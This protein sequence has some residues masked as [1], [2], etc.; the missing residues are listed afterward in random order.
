MQVE[1][2]EQA[3]EL[4]EKANASLQ[5]ELLTAADARKVLGL[6]GRGEK[7]CGFGVTSVAH[8]VDDASEI[9]RTTGT[10]MGKAKAVAETG[11]VMAHSAELTSALQ[12]GVISLDQA[13]VIAAAEASAP[14]SAAELVEVART[15]S[16]A[17]LKERARKAKL[18][19]EQHLGLA[20]RQ[21][22]ARFA[23]SHTD[24]LG[25]VH[26]HLAW[27]PHVGSPIVGRAEAEAARLARAA[28]AAGTTEPFERHLADA[29]ASMMSGGGKGRA[30]RPELV[31]LVSHEV[32]TR[33]WKDVRDGEIC[34]VPG[35]GP[36]SPLVAKD[37]AQDAFLSGVFYDGK[38]LRFLKRWSRG[39]PVEVAVAL[40]LGEPP[41]FE[42]VTCADCGNR[43]KTEFD[44]VDPIGAR[45]SPGPTSHSNLQPRCWSCHK[46]KT[47]TDRRAGK[48]R[49][50]GT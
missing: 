36:V 45:A 11:G 44:H 22:E 33:G 12:H 29:Y 35:V 18:E 3:V 31:V 6:Y 40:E 4:L 16:Y 13:T 5:P 39:I 47:E 26:V 14:G 27:E 23:R 38:D 19:A 43:F 2:L 50:G 10:S 37:I 21:R 42:G 1:L 24:D 41:G 34:K 28:R 46:A 17:V 15:Q 9:A 25:M 8:K 7:L 49:P 30:K 48:Y 32:A 20:E